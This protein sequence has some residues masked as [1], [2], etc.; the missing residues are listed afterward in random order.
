MKGSNYQN[1]ETT[2]RMKENLHQ[3]ILWI[4]DWY[5]EYTKSVQKI[6]HWKNNQ[7]NKW[8][9]ELNRQFSEV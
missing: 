4:K 3:F 5:P 1:D 6:K 7:I 8:A 9:D 2:H